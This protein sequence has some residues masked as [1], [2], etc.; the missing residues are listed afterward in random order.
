MRY[1]LYKYSLYSS[2]K[3]AS[4]EAASFSLK[5]NKQKL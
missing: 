2:N 3:I 4:S 1:K 5:T